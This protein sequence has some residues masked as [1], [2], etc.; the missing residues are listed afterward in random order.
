MQSLQE[1]YITL[2]PI[3]TTFVFELKKQWK[4]LLIFMGVS[5]VFALLG[6][7]LPYLLAP[8]NPLPET[9]AGF[10]QSSFSFITLIVIF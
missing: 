4:K 2:E 5:I 7:F 9:L 8:D 6:S 3:G 1:V 10:F